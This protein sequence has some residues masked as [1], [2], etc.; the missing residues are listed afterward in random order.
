MSSGVCTYHVCKFGRSEYGESSQRNGNFG[1]SLKYWIFKIS[2]RRREDC[3]VA[4]RVLNYGQQS[5][6]SSKG[7][8]PSA[9]QSQVIGHH[10]HHK[11][12]HQNSTP[13]SSMLLLQPQVRF[14]SW[15][16]HPIRLI[17][18]FQRICDSMQMCPSSRFLL[19]QALVN[20]Q[21]SWTP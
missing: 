21:D 20:Y 2:V 11:I 8:I 14:E 16:G 7:L 17:S 1:K 4:E 18:S 9:S 19:Y 13:T 3:V 6:D 12:S 10:Q 15:L 5:S